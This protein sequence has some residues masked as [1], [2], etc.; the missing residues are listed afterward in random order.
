MILADNSRA[1][2]FRSWWLEGGFT[3]VKQTSG[4]KENWVDLHHTSQVREDDVWE[5]DEEEEEEAEVGKP[6]ERKGES[7]VW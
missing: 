5:A 2:I 4:Q 3:Q 6:A 7:H 1:F